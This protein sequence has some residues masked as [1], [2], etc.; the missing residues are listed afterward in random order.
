MTVARMDHFTILTKDLE[1]TT[2]FYGDI[3]GFAPGPRPAFKFPGVWLYNDG[4]PI[5]HVIHR[6][7]IP[8]GT[9]VLD[10]M[11]YWA[12]G[13][14]S[15]VAKLKERGLRYDL[16]R[17]PE[18]GFGAGMWQLFFWDPSGARVELDFDKNET[19]PPGH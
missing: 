7:T 19:A 3:L 5:L 12:S 10:H 14:G 18:G 17:L 15:Y 1:A 13:L 16:R 11:A 9:G 8:D 2:R 4:R 6:D